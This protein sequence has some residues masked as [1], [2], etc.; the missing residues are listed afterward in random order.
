MCDTFVALPPFAAEVIFGKNSDR[1]PNEA[2]VLEY[3]PPADHPPKR[4]LRCTYR[5]LPQA[6]HEHNLGCRLAP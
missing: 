6:R 2:Q 4:R 1:Q 5:S 3:R